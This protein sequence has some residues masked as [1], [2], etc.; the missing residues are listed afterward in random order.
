MTGGFLTVLKVPGPTSHDVVQGVR[1]RLGLKAGHLGTLDPA[2]AGVLVVA[3]GAATRLTAHLAGYKKGYRSEIWLGLSTDSLDL[4]GAVTAEADASRVRLEPVLEA[5][6]SLLGERD[7]RPPMASA[8]KVGGQPLHRAYRRGETIE[9]P[10]RKITVHKAE[11]VE[12]RAGA[13]A[14]VVVDW[15]VSSGTYVRVLAEE[16]GAALGLP[17]LLG[18]LLRTSV[19][20]FS[21]TDAVPLDEVAPGRILPMA[22]AFHGA[23]RVDLSEH[24]RQMVLHGRPVKVDGALP[25]GKI[26][27][28]Y[29]GELLAMG[30]KG[31][32]VWRPSTVLGQADGVT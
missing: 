23:P 31:G 24:D 21:L 7:Q 30:E 25:D 13:R 14:E 29:H 17:A 3:V 15:E 1:R 32:D 11:L 10:P 19:G 5:L 4:E 8:V 12:F 26:P 18:T 28:F 6:R 27:A 16:L 20:P 22:T 9:A 2:A